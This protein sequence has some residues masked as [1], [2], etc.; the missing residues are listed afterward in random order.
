MKFLSK[1]Q[2]IEIFNKIK[3]LIKSF[4]GILHKRNKIILINRMLSKLL[5]KFKVYRNFGLSKYFIKLNKLKKI[6][7]TNF[8]VINFLFNLL[9]KTHNLS[10]MKTTLMV[11]ASLGI[12]P[13]IAYIYL[14]F[15]EISIKFFKLL[16]KFY[17]PIYKTVLPNL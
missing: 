15:I 17:H 10:K 16:S 5:P 12:I 4:V 1:F 14:P 13:K 9:S 6:I 11:S 8:K 7:L 3:I 2:F